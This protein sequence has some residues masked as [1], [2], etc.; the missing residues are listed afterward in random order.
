MNPAFK[1]LYA[2][3]N[4]YTPT[5]V[6]ADFVPGDDPLRPAE[7]PADDPHGE[8]PDAPVAERPDDE[9]EPTPEDKKRWEA[10]LSR[11][12]HSAGHPTNRN[13]ARMLHDA[14]LPKW[15]IKAAMNYSCPYCQETKPG[16]MASKQIPPGS[17]RPLPQAWE[18]VALDV[19]E[20][21][22]PDQDY[23]IKFLLM[24]DVATRFKVTEP[25]FVYKHGKV[26]VE[27]SEMASGQTTSQGSMPRQC[28]KPHIAAV[29][30]LLWLGWH[31]GDT[32]TRPRTM[33]TWC[34]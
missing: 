14:S 9:P 33:G 16:G 13:M 24:T 28:Q 8:Q 6:P 27:N 30:R 21:T 15:K 25:L 11:F 18:Q 12:H 2:I 5:E 34:R 20:W 22:V 19:G 17:L 10:Q 31:S 4:E 26:K 32:S 3:D 1:S 29:R 23:K 7:E